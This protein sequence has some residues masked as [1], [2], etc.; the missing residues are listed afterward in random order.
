MTR[1]SRA[2]DLT[3]RT[4]RTRTAEVTAILLGSLAEEE[5][6]DADERA[7]LPCE[8]D[9]RP[10]TDEGLDSRT[11]SG[12]VQGGNR[13]FR[14]RPTGPPPPPPSRPQPATTG[15]ASA[16]STGPAPTAHHQAATS[17]AAAGSPTGT[18]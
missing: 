14:A 12:D 11:T 5:S 6:L 9:L 7:T 10:G 18:T 2:E 17:R 1:N 3:H 16:D 4:I 13:P 8:R 15:P